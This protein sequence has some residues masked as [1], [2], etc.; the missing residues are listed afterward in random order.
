MIESRYIKVIIRKEYLQVCEN[1]EKDKDIS[2]AFGNEIDVT[3]E[4]E[5]IGSKLE[6]N[7]VSSYSR[8]R[9]VGLRQVVKK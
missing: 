8:K 6:E 5:K 4:S 7:L 9:P 1:S 2:E 3:F